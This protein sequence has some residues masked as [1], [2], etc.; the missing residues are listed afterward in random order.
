MGFAF[1]LLAAV[2]WVTAQIDWLTV[3]VHAPVGVR[4]AGLDIVPFL[5]LVVAFLAVGDTIRSNISRRLLLGLVFGLSSGLQLLNS[6][7]NQCRRAH[8]SGATQTQHS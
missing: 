7:E 3:V 6:C 2:G 4:R 8:F 5:L 1:S